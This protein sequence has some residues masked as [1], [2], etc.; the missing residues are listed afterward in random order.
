MPAYRTGVQDAN[1]AG[2]VNGGQIMKLCDDAAVIAADAA[3]R[4][5]CRHGGDR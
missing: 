5:P 1:V 4:W 3:G 2:N